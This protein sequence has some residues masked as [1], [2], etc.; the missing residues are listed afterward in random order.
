MTLLRR[1]SDGGAARSP[2]LFALP[3]SQSLSVLASSPEMAES[4][5]LCSDHRTSLVLVAKFLASCS[6]QERAGRAGRCRGAISKH[7]KG[8]GTEQGPPGAAG[9]KHHGPS[10]RVPMGF[11]LLQLEP[12]AGAKPGVVRRSRALPASLGGAPGVPRASSSSQSLLCAAIKSS[13]AA[14]PAPCPFLPLY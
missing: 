8:L 1:C 10:P 6:Q 14:V 4:H 13:T 12:A 5:P 9:R 2:G 11:A 7:R 3:A